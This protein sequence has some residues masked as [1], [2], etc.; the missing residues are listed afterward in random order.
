MST[1]DLNSPPPKHNF[2]VS[3]DRAE[4]PAEMAVRLMKDVCLFLAALALVGVVI[5]ICIT[6]LQGATATQ[7]EKKWA[8]ST[9]GAAAGGVVGYLVRK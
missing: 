8:M 7:E 6:T 3:V 9:I 1:I 4:T 5:Y 2:R